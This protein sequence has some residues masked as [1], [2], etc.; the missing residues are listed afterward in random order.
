MLLL[1][2]ILEIKDDEIKN[3][4][5]K[6]DNYQSAANLV[7]KLNMISTNESMSPDIVQDG[8]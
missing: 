7:P 1:E 5:L 8:H 3:L 6:L 2:K 4:K